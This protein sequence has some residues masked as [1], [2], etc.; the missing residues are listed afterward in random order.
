MCFHKT[1]SFTRVGWVNEVCGRN[2]RRCN[3]LLMSGYSDSIENV[4]IPAC[5]NPVSL[6][7]TMRTVARFEETAVNAPLAQS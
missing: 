3:T 6:F 1:D 2:M 7:T 5:F 4:S